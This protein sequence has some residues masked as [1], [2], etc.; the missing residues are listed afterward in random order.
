MNRKKRTQVR[1][2]EQLLDEPEPAAELRIE[3]SLDAHG[4]SG[5]GRHV[6][7]T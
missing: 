1:D 7:A 4:M 6:G 5:N 3:S 2:R